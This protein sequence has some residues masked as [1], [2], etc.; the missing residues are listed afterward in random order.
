MN[1]LR[2]GQPA[3]QT[4]HTDYAKSVPVP[5]E[6]APDAIKLMQGWEMGRESIDNIIY[7]KGNKAQI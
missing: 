4:R 3:P 7:Q 5:H 1:T 2:R 6:L